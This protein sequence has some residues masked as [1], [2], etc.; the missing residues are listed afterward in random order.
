MSDFGSDV[1]ADKQARKFAAQLARKEMDVGDFELGDP[2][3]GGV[4]KR[5]DD[6]SEDDF[7]D[8]MAGQERGQDAM[9]KGLDPEIGEE[10]PKK[11][12]AGEMTFTQGDA[13]PERFQ[14]GLKD[15]LKSR[16]SGVRN[17]TPDQKKEIG[18]IAKKTWEF[19]K[20]RELSNKTKGITQDPKHKKMMDRMYM[21]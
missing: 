7:Y 18:Q 5:G 17:L 9:E 14:Q 15:F 21:F 3:A 2:P 13:S 10:P 4:N 20:N 16:T 12:T 11:K 6:E 8:R 19:N 1:E